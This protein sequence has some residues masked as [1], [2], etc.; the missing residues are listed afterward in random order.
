MSVEKLIL[1]DEDCKIE[2]RIE[3]DQYCF[4]CE[5]EK[6]YYSFR[7]NRG[8]AHLLMLCLQEHLK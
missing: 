8:Q 4:Y 2:V 1:G 7:L 5:D 3:A 6:L